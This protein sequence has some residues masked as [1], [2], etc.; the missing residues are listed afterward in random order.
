[1]NAIDNASIG[2]GAT[3]T[4]VVMLQFSAVVVA[5]SFP[6]MESIQVSRLTHVTIGRALSNCTEIP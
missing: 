6:L 4:N 1:M 2:R 5:E 3:V